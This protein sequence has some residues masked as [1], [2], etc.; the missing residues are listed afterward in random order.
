MVWRYTYT[1]CKEVMHSC[2][3]DYIWKDLEFGEAT[4]YWNV[5]ISIFSFLLYTT[6]WMFG[7]KTC[8]V[9]IM[10]YEV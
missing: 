5:G 2:R 6:G 8:V 4:F 9:Y 7:G 3:A 1:S 10:F